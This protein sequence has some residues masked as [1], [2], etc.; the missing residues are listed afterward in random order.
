MII[1]P[2]TQKARRGARAR[3]LTLIAA[4]LTTLAL[5]ASCTKSERANEVTLSKVCMAAAKDTILNS[6]LQRLEMTFFAD[7]RSRGLLAI[8]KLKLKSMREVS[9]SATLGTYELVFDFT[10]QKGDVLVLR[11]DDA[12]GGVSLD[13]PN[14]VMFR[15]VCEVQWSHF[16]GRPFQKSF[17]IKAVSLDSKLRALDVE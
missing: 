10:D 14:Q 8:D 16:K 11:N 15:G 6:T 1:S 7:K 12:T 2:S 3:G 13:G 5:T 9:S 17:D 4:L